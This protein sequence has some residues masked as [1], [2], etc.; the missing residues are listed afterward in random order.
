[1]VSG[2]RSETECGIETELGQE[3]RNSLNLDVA[4]GRLQKSC[5]MLPI[6]LK[7]K[8]G[9]RR[10]RRVVHFNYL[11]PCHFPPQETR[12]PTA[13]SRR[14][15][16]PDQLHR[17]PVG[18]R[19]VGSEPD[20][21]QR[22]PVGSGEVE[23]GWLENP[24]SPVTEVL[25]HPE[26][27]VGNNDTPISDSAVADNPSQPTAVPESSGAQVAEPSQTRASPRREIREPAWLKD[28]VRTVA[29]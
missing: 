16:E 28:Y 15:Q 17:T 8:P 7:R 25:H 3:G 19:G 4:P 1:M 21:M 18:S 5:L 6:V 27:L 2:S 26:V 11:K 13:S 10:Q 20:Q 24:A 12:S 29:Y 9:R 23:L 22:T 14:L